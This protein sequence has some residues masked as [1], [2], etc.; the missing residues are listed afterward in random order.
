MLHYD[1][2]KVVNLIRFVIIIN[3]IRFFIEICCNFLER[4][5]FKKWALKKVHKLKKF[6][7]S[8]IRS[9][10]HVIRM[11]RVYCKVFKLIFTKIL[12]LYYTYYYLLLYYI[13]YTTKQIFQLTNKNLKILYLNSITHV[14][15]S[16]HVY[17]PY[18]IYYVFFVIKML[19]PCLK[20]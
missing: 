2:D 15:V 13:Y 6:K 19:K 5:H 10:F 3:V 17:A 7:T 1:N 12:L 16:F 11:T 14:K 4:H 18:I 20:K 8:F 9:Y